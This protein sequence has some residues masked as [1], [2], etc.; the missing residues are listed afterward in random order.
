MIRH[1]YC[2]CSLVTVDP[3]SPEKGTL[4][5]YQAVLEKDPWK[6]MAETNYGTLSQLGKVEDLGG[7]QKLRI[8]NAKM[9]LWVIPANGTKRDVIYMNSVDYGDVYISAR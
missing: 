3:K 8:K 5:W 6:Y 2:R 1:Q 9:E 7:E 4:S